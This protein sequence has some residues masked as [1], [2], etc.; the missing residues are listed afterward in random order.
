MDIESDENVIQG[1]RVRYK[2]T[3]LVEWDY[4]VDHQCKDVSCHIA[5]EEA[6]SSAINVKVL[7][8]EVSAMLMVQRHPCVP[9]V[10]G[11][12]RVDANFIIVI[13]FV[14]IFHAKIENYF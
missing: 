11:Q 14:I 2:H 1:C 6:Q 5:N 10:L 8:H 13:N 3:N 4:N 7:G 9:L 12:R